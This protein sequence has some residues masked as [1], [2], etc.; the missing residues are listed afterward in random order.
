MKEAR[1]GYYPARAAVDALRP[2]F[3]EEVAKPPASADQNPPRFGK[4]AQSEFHGIL[5]WAIGQANGADL[6]DVRERAE[7]KM[8]DNV[9][10]D[11]SSFFNGH[12]AAAQT[13]GHAAANS[14][15][16]PSSYIPP[17]SLYVE[18]LEA[19]FWNRPSLRAIYDTA[20]MQSCSPWAVC[21]HCVARVLACIR[22]CVIY[23]GRMAGRC[24]RPRAGRAVPRTRATQRDR[25][26][27]L[28]DLP[29]HRLRP[30]P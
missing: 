12:Q 2:M 13:N 22:P 6:G 17:G 26:G 7:Q 21:A 14:Q 3:I 5:A 25:P 4:V 24:H 11:V 23:R 29:G 27:V 1:A 8:P 19:D 28:D 18:H 20:L 9:I 30:G 10:V 15:T 16:K